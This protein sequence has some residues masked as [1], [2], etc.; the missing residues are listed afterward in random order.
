MSGLAIGF[1]SL[2]LKK[3][4]MRDK[5]PPFYT[6]ISPVFHFFSFLGFFTTLW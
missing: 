5:K 6:Y 2:K 1:T 4:K 3:K